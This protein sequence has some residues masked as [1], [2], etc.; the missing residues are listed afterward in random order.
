V[1]L[2]RQFRRYYSEPLWEFLRRR[3]VEVAAQKISGEDGTLC[4]IAHGLGFSEQ[5]HFT[6]PFKRFMGIT[7]SEFRLRQRSPKSGS[8]GA[9]Q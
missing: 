6:R 7:P 9:N 1:H 5:A 8:K 3:R 2:S 4:E